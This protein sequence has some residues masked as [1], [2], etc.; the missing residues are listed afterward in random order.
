MPGTQSAMAAA[1]PGAAGAAAPGPGRHCWQCAG[2]AGSGYFCPACGAILPLPDDL[3]YFA[4]LGLP[5]RLVVDP[6]RLQA[7]YYELHRQLHP[8]RFQT[9]PPEAR[10]ASLRNTAAVNRAYAT[11]RDPLDRGLYWLALQ[12]ES[13]GT[14]NNRVPPALAALVFETQEQLE[15]LRG[16]RGSAAAA[17]I[18]DGLRETRAAI[19]AQRDALLARLHANYSAWDAGGDPAALRQELKALL[20]DLAYLGT[21]LRDLDREFER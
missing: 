21:L 18:A 7:R 9:A 3:D 16:A 1:R 2:A 15:A 10:V 8:D 19:V 6:E 17:A 4:I 20:S 14:N 11:L 12:G 13:V 5:R